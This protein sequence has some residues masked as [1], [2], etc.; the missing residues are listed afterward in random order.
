MELGVTR[1]H[2]EVVKL[3]GRLRYRYSYAQNVLRHSVETGFLAGL[4]ASELG[5][6][7]RQARRA[8]LLHDIGKAVSR[9]AGRRPRRHRRPAAAQERRRT[10]S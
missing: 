1:L 6:N 2:P 10:R 4:M 3:L 7:V 9:R 5:L 8:G